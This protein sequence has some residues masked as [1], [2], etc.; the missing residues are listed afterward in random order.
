M[1]VSIKLLSNNIKNKDY[2]NMNTKTED[3]SNWQKIITSVPFDK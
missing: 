2:E 3:K 1:K